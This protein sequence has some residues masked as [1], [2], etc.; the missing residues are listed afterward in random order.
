[1]LS[2]GTYVMSPRRPAGVESN[3][4]AVCPSLNT[5]FVLA[6]SVFFTTSQVFRPRYSQLSQNRKLRHG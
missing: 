3:A 5:A 1:M 6:K 2:S 4:S